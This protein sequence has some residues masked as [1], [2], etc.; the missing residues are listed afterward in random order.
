MTAKQAGIYAFEREFNL[1]QSLTAAGESPESIEIVLATHLHFDHAGGF[2]ARGADGV[3]RPRF[4][5]AQ[6]VVRRGEF[7][8]AMHPNERTKGS[9]FLENYQPLAEAGVLQLVDEDATI[10]PG[11][12]IRRTGGHTGH[13]QIV[14]IE[15]KG[16]TAAFVADLIPTTAHVRE[17]W[18]MGF[19][20]YPMDTLAAKQRMIAEAMEKETLVFFEHDPAVAAGYIREQDG[21]RRVEPWEDQRFESL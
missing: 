10:M 16:Q 2:T 1:Q 9:Y 6:Y 21:K 12:R 13:H 5:R 7:E 8:D 17:A 18:I 15:S 3:V 19:D 11:V 14:L 20:L 4:P